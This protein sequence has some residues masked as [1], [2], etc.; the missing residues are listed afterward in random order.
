MQLHPLVLG[1]ASGLRLKFGSAQHC[2]DPT[3]EDKMLK[4]HFRVFLWIEGGDVYTPT[5]TPA[6]P[7]FPL[8]L[9]S[10]VLMLPFVQMEGRRLMFWF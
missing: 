6:H 7:E 4:P 8:P 9:T 3:T 1:D 2:E 10:A 5:E